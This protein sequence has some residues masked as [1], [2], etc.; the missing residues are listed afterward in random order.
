MAIRLLNIEIKNLREQARL[1][2]GGYM[3]DPFALKGDS[4]DYPH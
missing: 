1:A 4:S 2:V 3:S